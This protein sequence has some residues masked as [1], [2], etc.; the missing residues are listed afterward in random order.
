MATLTAD[1][2]TP[3]GSQVTQVTVGWLKKSGL[4]DPIQPVV[5]PIKPGF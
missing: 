5:V 1:D 4:V 3:A 2:E